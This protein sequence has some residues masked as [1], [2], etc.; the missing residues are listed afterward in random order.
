MPAA[1]TDAYATASEYRDRVEKSDEGDDTTID[2][3]LL[4]V[5]RLFDRQCRR[6]FTKDA[7]ALARTYEGN[8]RTRIRIDDVADTSGVVVKVDLDAD[9]DYDQA[10]ETLTVDSHYWLGPVDADKGSEPWPY[11]YLDIVPNN[12]RLSVWPAQPRALE[13]T[14]TFGW[15]AVPGAIKEAVIMIVRELRDLQQ[16]GMTMAL[17][18]VDQVVNLSPTAFSILQRI[19]REYERKNLFV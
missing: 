18:S 6:F 16:A 7:S 4:A 14:A 12:G 2:A 11:R 19:K 5:S 3:Q 8:G 10:D 15:P 13:V 1:V 9:F 17:E